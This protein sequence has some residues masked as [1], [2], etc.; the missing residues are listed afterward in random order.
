[1]NNE[2]VLNKIGKKETDTYN[3]KVTLVIFVMHNEER[4]HVEFNTQRMY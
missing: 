4:G 1:M 3:Q 2:E